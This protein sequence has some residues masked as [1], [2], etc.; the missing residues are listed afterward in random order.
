M[1]LTVFVLI[2]FLKS[3]KISGLSTANL[4]VFSKW[5]KP[6]TEMMLMLATIR[7]MLPLSLTILCTIPL[8]MFSCM[9]DRWEISQIDGILI[10]N[11]LKTLM[12]LVYLLTIMI[13]L[14]SFTEMETLDSSKVPLPLPFAQEV[15]PSSTTEVSR[16]S[17]VAMILSIVRSF[18][19][20]LTAIQTCL[21]SLKQWTE[22][23]NLKVLLT[24]T[25][26]R[27]G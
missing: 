4:L 21:S 5:E 22:P 23:D 14:D 15:S 10:N 24:I 20:T 3:Q 11:T 8:R 7:N 6:S 1:A 9:A 19:A 16:A 13:T 27:N 25:S 12:L 26:L 2:L 17:L 18:G